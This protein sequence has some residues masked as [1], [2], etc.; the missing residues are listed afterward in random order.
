MTD[1]RKKRHG[2]VLYDEDGHPIGHM[3]GAMGPPCCQCGA[4]SNALCD[5]P[6]GHEGRTCDRPLCLRCAPTVGVD[7]NFCREHNEQGPNLLLFPPRKKSLA[8][9]TAEAFGREYTGPRQPAPPQYLKLPRTP[10]KEK[11]WRVI[12]LATAADGVSRINAFSAWTDELNARATAQTV[13]CQSYERVVI[14]TWEEYKAAFRA[15]H[16]NRPRRERTPPNDR[17]WRVR[18]A[19]DGAV[20]TRWT[21]E[22]TAIR[23]AEKVG[24]TVET[25][26]EHLRSEKT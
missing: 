21:D 15:R 17:R 11:R 22:I 19:G 10:P 12:R 18:Q 7:K 20:L 2:Y 25:W 14:Q 13:G 23:H 16:P 8:E 5:F 9:L 26:D 6:L 24:G 1:D 3:C 4:V